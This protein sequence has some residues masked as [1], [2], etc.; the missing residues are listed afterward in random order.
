MK[1]VDVNR[2]DFQSEKELKD[3]LTAFVLEYA[4]TMNK[5][6]KDICLKEEK[7]PEKDFF[8]EF[9]K[10]YLPVFKKFCSDKKRAYGGQADSYGI[11]TNF[12][13]I[14]KNTENSVELKNKNRAEVY[15]KT[16]NDTHAEYLFI[17][18]RKNNVWRIDNSKERWYGEEDWES[19]I[20]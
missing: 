19:M 4:S 16:R 15:F 2:T 20:L 18:L 9:E 8:P 6:E 3:F 12:D 1:N 14:E 11:P 5:I 17:V 7:E 10:R 13:G